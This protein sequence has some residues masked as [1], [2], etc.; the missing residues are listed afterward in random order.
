MTNPLARVAE[1]LGLHKL[2]Q[3]LA[4]YRAD[5]DRVRELD[6]EG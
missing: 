6:E 1:V 4:P 5:G 3:L 2:A